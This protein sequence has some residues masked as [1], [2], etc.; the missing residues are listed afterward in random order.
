MC[1]AVCRPETEKY[2]FSSKGVFARLSTTRLRLFEPSDPKVKPI[3]PVGLF[4]IEVKI[5]ESF[6]NLD[7]ALPSSRFIF[8]INSSR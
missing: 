4:V 7:P 2:R 1:F 6:E 5:S 8:T 3:I